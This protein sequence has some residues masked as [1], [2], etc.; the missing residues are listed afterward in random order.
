MALTH[1]VAI[2]TALSC[3]IAKPRHKRS[4]VVSMRPSH[5]KLN[6]Q[7][8]RQSIIR[9]QHCLT[10]DPRRSMRRRILTH[11]DRLKL[12]LKRP[13]TR[14][15]LLLL[16]CIHQSCAAICDAHTHIHMHRSEW[17]ARHRTTLQARHAQGP[18]E[19]QMAKQVGLPERGLTFLGESSWMPLCWT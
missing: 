19:V 5:N 1:Q 7:T 15:A 8:I 16:D 6:R 3:Q 14:P 9:Q 18:G 11:S 2:G 12:L 10:N 17:H 4:C 13:P